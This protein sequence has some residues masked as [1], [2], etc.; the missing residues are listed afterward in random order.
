MDAVF[1]PNGES[2]LVFKSGDLSFVDGK[3]FANAANLA[4]G[5]DGKTY[6][7]Q[8]SVVF[9]SDGNTFIRFGE[10]PTFLI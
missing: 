7:N 1:G 6:L 3:T 4:L 5:P 8:G 9:G 10:N 2:H